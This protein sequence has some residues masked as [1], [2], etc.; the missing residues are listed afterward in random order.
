[1]QIRK[2]IHSNLS[3]IN[4]I[5]TTWKNK[6]SHNKCIV[7]INILYILKFKI[8]PHSFLLCTH[9]KNR[10]HC[11]FYKVQIDN[12]IDLFC[13]LYYEILY[14]IILSFG[15]IKI[16]NQYATKINCTLNIYIYILIQIWFDIWI[17]IWIE[18]NVYIV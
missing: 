11:F 10:K 5:L 7:N 9:N 12:A 8:C 2:H 1:M 6:C 3:H 4:S 14:N 15:S 17:D 18:G 16:I 13:K